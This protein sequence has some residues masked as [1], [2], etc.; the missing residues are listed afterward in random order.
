MPKAR[1]GALGV[2]KKRADGPGGAAAKRA[3]PKALASNEAPARAGRSEGARPAPRRA[4][5][6]GAA[7]KS[8]VAREPS[9]KSPRRAIAPPA[10]EAEQPSS[11]DRK[12][13]GRRARADEGA[14]RSPATRSAP[15][16]VVVPSLDWEDG[17]HAAF[18]SD[19]IVDRWVR[20]AE[21]LM[22]LL[23]EHGVSGVDARTD[24]KS[25]RLSW[26]SADGL[27]LAEARAEVVCSWSPSTGALAMA[28]ADPLVRPVGIPCLEGIPA[29]RA[30]IDE[31][32]AF[33]VAMQAAEVRGADYLYDVETPHAWYFLA[34]TRLSFFP[35][36]PLLS[37]SPP[38][39]PVREIR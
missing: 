29:E 3:T 7:K 13:R 36:H 16:P 37:S 14:A 21:E 4:R 26:L 15:V 22:R 30:A 8:D 34:L 19:D 11:A 32:M 12:R 31:E 9:R 27:L 39:P 5:G 25:G 23:D 2:A 28:W 33:R 38:P 17:V 1:S 6:D 24:L 20:R 35:E 18:A 10:R